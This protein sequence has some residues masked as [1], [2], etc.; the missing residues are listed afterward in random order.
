MMNIHLNNLQN[1][2]NNV[3]CYC[4]KFLSNFYQLDV[5]GL[6]RRLSLVQVVKAL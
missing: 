3:H 1:R 5:C 6:P 4:L 2:I